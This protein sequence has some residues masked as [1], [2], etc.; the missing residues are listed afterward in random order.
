[1]LLRLRMLLV[2]L[3][4]QVA[5]RGLHRGMPQI[6]PHHQQRRPRVELVCRSQCVVAALS[7]RAWSGAAQAL[8]VD[9]NSAVTIWCA[10]LLVSDCTFPYR[11]IRS[12]SGQAM[13]LLEKRYARSEPSGTV[14]QW[15]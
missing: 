13:R 4:V 3:N 15:T 10:A 1:M 5:F 12:G 8:A 2:G 14:Y 6:V 11:S 7:S 9:T